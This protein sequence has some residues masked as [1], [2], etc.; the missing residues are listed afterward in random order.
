[1]FKRDRNALKIIQ[2]KGGLVKPS[3]GCYTLY[4]WKKG[5]SKDQKYFKADLYDLDGNLLRSGIIEDSYECLVF[6]VKNLLN[7]RN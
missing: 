5:I 2:Y 1:M 6:E 7:I 4:W 3:K